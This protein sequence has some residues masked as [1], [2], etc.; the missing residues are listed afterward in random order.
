MRLIPNEHK[1]KLKKATEVSPT[2]TKCDLHLQSSIQEDKK[3]TQLLTTGKEEMYQRKK[4]KVK[5]TT[6]PEEFE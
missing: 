2:M 1:N 4:K 3:Q 6:F 5:I